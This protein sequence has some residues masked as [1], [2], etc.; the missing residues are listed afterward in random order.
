MDK[1]TRPVARP[2]SKTGEVT[3]H[4]RPLWKE[5]A[6]G[7][8]F[9]EKTIT[10]PY[11]DGWVVMP[12][13]A[14][15]GS[16]YS[17]EVIADYVKQ[18]GPV[19]FITGEELPVFESVEQA[20]SYAE[21]R[22]DT[23]LDEK[24]PI[25]FA[26]GGIKMEQQMELFE[27]G[28]LM[29]EGGMTDEVSGNEVPVGSTRSEV[30][31]DI[32]AKLSEGEFVFPADVVRYFGLEKLMQLRQEAKAGLKRMEE[33]GQMGNSEEATIP[34]DLPFTLEDLILMEDETEPQKFSG[35]GTPLPIADVPV[36]TASES[37]LSMAQGFTFVT[38]KNEEGNTLIIPFVNG[39]PLYPIPDGYSRV[40]AGDTGTG[41]D[42]STEDAVTDAPVTPTVTPVIEREGSGGEN[43]SDVMS[44]DYSR[45][46]DEQL[47]NELDRINSAGKVAGLIGLANPAMGLAV[48]G[49]SKLAASQINKALETPEDQRLEGMPK[50]LYQGTTSKG[51][52]IYSPTEETT[53]PIARTDS[54]AQKTSTT[55]P[56]VEV[57]TAFPPTQ[58]TPAMPVDN[59]TPTPAT[60]TFGAKTTEATAGT[61]TNPMEALAISQ[62]VPTPSSLPTYDEAVPTF[63]MPDMG[64]FATGVTEPKATTDY[65]PIASTTISQKALDMMTASEKRALGIDPLARKVA[66][67]TRKAEQVAPEDRTP[68]QRDAF[69]AEKADLQRAEYNAW[70]AREQAKEEGR[71][72][73]DE[74]GGSAPDTPSYSGSTAGKAEAEAAMGLDPFGGAGRDIDTGGNSKSTSGGSSAGK[75]SSMSS[76]ESAASMGYGRSRGGEFMYKGGL[77]SKKKAA[78]KAK[79]NTSR[80]VAARKKK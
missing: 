43:A 31:D 6:T 77:A 52:H 26:K 48:K 57:P 51:V 68:A 36:R 11:G 30:R 7:E 29:Q 64:Q 45:M 54:V 15:D 3:K 22:S 55:K 65:A 4:G 60:S 61:T 59:T 5:E 21:N 49:F 73:I 39:Q 44:K 1:S 67:V 33:M 37:P 10:V 71:V 16:Q 74:F 58:P 19:D 72:S 42:T 69:Y 13:V 79:P 50:G 28:G 78:A 9:S 63:A 47:Q 41:T 53:R 35:G 56:T 17:E 14:E 20:A 25:N 23:M 8:H 27:D 32:D 38:Y 70:E 34:D 80:G 46:T 76:A 40:T 24:A 18:Y 2:R 75:G 62:D 12:T 66:D